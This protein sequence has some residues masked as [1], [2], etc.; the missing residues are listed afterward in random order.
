MA[1]EYRCADFGIARAARYAGVVRS[2]VVLLA[3]ALAVASC[4]SAKHGGAKPARH[5][6]PSHHT[7]KPPHHDK[8][9]ERYAGEVDDAGARDAGAPNEPAEVFAP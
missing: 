9:K 4:S 1:R 6:K 5:K 8:P 7:E 3:C 2:W